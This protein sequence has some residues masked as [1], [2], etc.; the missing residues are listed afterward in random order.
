MSLDWQT[1]DFQDGTGPWLEA[2]APMGFAYSVDGHRGAYL[3]VLCDSGGGE[4]WKV[5]RK[6]ERGAK[7]ACQRHAEA[8]C[9]DW[10]RFVGEPK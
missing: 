5:S 3:A 6:T 4:V 1:I 2:E 10:I 9:G 8:M 7:A